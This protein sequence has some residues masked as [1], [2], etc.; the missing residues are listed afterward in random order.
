MKMRTN[1]NLAAKALTALAFLGISL[2]TS[3]VTW[4]NKPLNATARAKPM[5]MLVAS[6][7][8]KFF[9]EAYNDA[10]DINGDGRLDRRFT[11]SITYYGLY[12]STLCYGYTGTGATAYFEPR[13]TADNLGRCLTGGT[14]GEWSGNWLNYITTELHKSFAPLFTAL[15]T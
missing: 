14:S 15:S 5:T 9:Y 7:D 4:P 6:K 10:S 3:A 12:D 2:T 8:H 13:S 1:A 11:P